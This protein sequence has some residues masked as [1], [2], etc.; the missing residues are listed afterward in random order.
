MKIFIILSM[1]L[2][3]QVAHS[4]DLTWSKKL[5]VDLKAK[6]L[7][8][9][10]CQPDIGYFSEAACRE[11]KYKA[12]LN[13]KFKSIDLENPKTLLLTNGKVSVRIERGSS[14]TV[15]LVNQKVIDLKE[16]P[17]PDMLKKK[18]KEVLPKV[19]KFSFWLSVAQADDADEDK[20]YKDAVS[21]AVWLLL[22]STRDE[23]VC[24][25]AQHVADLCRPGGP[26][27]TRF[28]G[29]VLTITED[30]QKRTDLTRSDLRAYT[31]ALNKDS[32][33]FRTEVDMLIEQLEKVDS[34]KAVIMKCPA[35]NKTWETI[36]GCQERIAVSLTALLK[37][38]DDG[39]NWAAA[40]ILQPLKAQ[41][42]KINPGPLS[43]YKKSKPENTPVAN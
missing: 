2:F 31:K 13:W 8:E 25:N 40:E 3:F 19:A 43:P 34:K 6:N 27:N 20:S 15:F 17:H 41:L 39:K 32:A 28:S 33:R 23:D 36:T 26:A 7:N 1:N 10:F 42:E 14:P 18:I 9:I 21:Q 30:I 12:D 22:L 5:V 4:G 35:E 11:I 37:R 29:I 24:L 16:Y 38:P